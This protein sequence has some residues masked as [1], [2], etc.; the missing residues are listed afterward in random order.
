MLSVAADAADQPAPAAAI[1]RLSWLPG[2]WRMEKAGRVVDEQ[3]MAPSGGMMLGM[4]RTV[5]KGRVLEYEFV[6][7]RE[8]PAGEL[9]YVAQPS[10]QKEA[11][12]KCLSLTDT[13][14]VFENKEHDFPQRIGYRLLPDGALVAYIEGPGKDGATKRIEYPYKRVQ[15]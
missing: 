13:E 8:G 15:P 4:A 12:F 14:I 5:A 7:I 6:L 11:T 10:G 3:W 9:S 2:H 1:E